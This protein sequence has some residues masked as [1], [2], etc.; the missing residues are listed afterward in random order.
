M[1]I[2][3]KQLSLDVFR[4]Y[5]VLKWND[6]EDSHVPLANWKQLPKDVPTLFIKA[7]FAAADGAKYEGYL[8][9]LEN[10][11]AFGLF[12]GENEYVL[13]LNLPDMIADSMQ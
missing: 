13:N 4:E 8:I 1:S 6:A 2:T 9:G 3:R 7:M 12:I 11:Y 5:P 10:F